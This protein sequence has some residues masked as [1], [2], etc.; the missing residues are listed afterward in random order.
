MR[1]A[2]RGA[3]EPVR[4]RTDCGLPARSAIRADAPGG[5]D[6]AAVARAIDAVRARVSER[7][8]AVVALARELGLR[9]REASTLDARAALAQ[10]QRTGTITIACGTKGGRPRD[11]VAVSERGAAAL[12]AAAAAQGAARSLIPPDQSWAQ[13]AGHELRAARALVQAETG[14]GL[15]ALR[16]AYACERYEALTGSAPRICGGE[17]V[18]PAI[19]ALAR[20]IIAG[21]LGHERTDVTSAYL[22]RR[23]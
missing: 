15:H 21:E 19:D 18:D 10:Y 2:T 6:R 23:R 4:A 5:V 17:P 1:H 7:A 8:A 11:L 16:A 12:E 9:A 13:W 20:S 14:G 3:W 22:G